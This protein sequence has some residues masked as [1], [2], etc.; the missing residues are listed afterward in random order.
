MPE[1]PEVEYTARQLRTQVAGATISGVCVFCQRTIGHPAPEDFA[2]EIAGRRVLAVR[3]RGKFLVV[4]LSGDLFLSIHR[5]MTGNLLLLPAGWQID[6]SLRE[7]D[8]AAWDTEGPRFYQ[9][10]QS[11]RNSRNSAAIAAVLARETAYCRFC[12]NFADGRRLLFTDP[13]KFGRIGLW[14]RAQEAAF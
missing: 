6:T 13:R 5:R 8:A 7:Q 11:S 2:A 10:E 9:E 1:L 14:P 12:F 3:R 4:D